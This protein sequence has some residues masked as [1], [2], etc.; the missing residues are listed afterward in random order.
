MGILYLRMIVSGLLFGFVAW[1]APP[2]AVW[3]LI[4][5]GLAGLAIK[6]ENL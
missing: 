1:I 2:F 5:M 3:T 4:G 6:M